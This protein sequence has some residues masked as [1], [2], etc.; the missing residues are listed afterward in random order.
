MADERAVLDGFLDWY[1]STLLHKCAGLSADQLA[2]R[3]VPPSNL[4]LLGMIRHMAEVERAWFRLRFSG[5]SLGRL[6]VSEENPDADIEDGTAAS[7]ESDYA[8]FLNELDAARAAAAGH[9]LDETFIG[10]RGKPISLR[11]VYVHMVEEYAR[12]CGHADL[13]R[14]RI[15]GVKG[16]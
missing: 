7:A 2:D 8:T 5:Q 1:R 16:S 3:A 6:Y 13:I 12:H 9:E 4:S 15:D 10:S 14:E 11:W